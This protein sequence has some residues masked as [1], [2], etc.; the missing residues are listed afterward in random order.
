MDLP[1]DVRCNCREGRIKSTISYAELQI[2]IHVFKGKKVAIL[3]LLI[4]TNQAACA[5]FA[6]RLPGRVY[7][8]SGD[9][10]G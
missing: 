10:C 5:C 7:G 9:E 4:G 1:V 6:D 8:E 3:E 2:A